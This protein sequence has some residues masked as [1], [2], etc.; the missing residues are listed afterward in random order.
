MYPIHIRL[1]NLRQDNNL[2]QKQ[3]AAYLGIPQQTYSNYERDTREIPAVH[4]IRLSQLY[5][6]NAD[7]LL[8]IDTAQTDAFDLSAPFVPDLSL[9]AVTLHLLKLNRHNR[10]ELIRFLSYLIHTQRKNG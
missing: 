5:H 6:V 9:E 1:K 3:V 7:S 8:G 4:I 10:L 2:S